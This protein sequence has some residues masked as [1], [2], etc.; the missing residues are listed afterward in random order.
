MFKE[1]K[2]A[3]AGEN[4]NRTNSLDMK[5]KSSSI[6][7]ITTTLWLILAFVGLSASLLWADT[8]YTGTGST[9]T[10]EAGCT[11]SP[12]TSTT[13]GWSGATSYKSSAPGNL[14]AC[15]VGGRLNQGGTAGTAPW[16]KLAPALG[17]SGGTYILYGTRGGGFSSDSPDAAFNI[18]YTSC[19][20]SASTTGFFHSGGGPPM[21]GR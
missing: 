3:I 15:T 14:A 6:T 8:V 1:G 11:L 19:T 13:G 16:V 10:P 4:S 21:I 9:A 7:S 12:G 18:T 17:G 5:M 20:G 2:E